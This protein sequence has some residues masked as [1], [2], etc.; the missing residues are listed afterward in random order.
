MRIGQARSKFIRRCRSTGLSD[1]TV[2][3]YR[4]Q[5]R[6]YWQWL[7]L[8]QRADRWLE[9]DVLRDYFAHL[10]KRVGRK[11]IQP[12]TV[13][14]AYR[15]V[16]ALCRWLLTEEEVDV[17]PFKK[18]KRPKV[19]KKTPRQTDI[20]D[21]KRLLL[22]IDGDGWI[23]LRDR[24]IICL[25]F[26]CGLRVGSLVALQ[27]DDIDLRNSLLRVRRAKGGDPQMVPLL[28]VV[29]MAFAEYIYQRPAVRTDAL[30]PAASG[31]QS[32]LDVGVQDSGV[33]LMLKRRCRAAGIEAKNP[34]SLRHG[35]AMH[36]L[37]HLGADMS[38]I[39]EILGHKDE[40]TT[41]KYYAHWKTDGLAKKYAK[42]IEDNGN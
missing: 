5:V 30:F 32:P 10:Q 24:L 17:D 20:E 6:Y 39:S 4:N 9:V 3:F 15:A 1:A 42:L 21:L 13:D 26:W 19:P 22:S 40:K 7:R 33:R 2:I 16:R 11:E 41:E 34:H 36:L 35:L 18:I 25:L 37:N 8:S 28:P 14:S 27:V 38:F 29:K 12:E 23:N 31:F